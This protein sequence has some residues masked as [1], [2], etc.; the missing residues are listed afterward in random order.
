MQ[1]FSG[2]E[3]LCIDIANNFGKDKT[4][5]FKGDK[6]TFTNRIQWVKDN[7]HKLEERI[8]E[9]D[10]DKYLYIKSVQA[11]RKVC[12]GEATG[13]LVMLDATCS[14]MQ[15]LSALTGCIKGARITNLLKG[16]VRYDAYTEVTNTMQGV[17]NNKG[18]NAFTVNRADAKQA[19]MTSLYGSTATP[20]EIFKEDHIISAFYD[21]CF[22][23]APGAFSTLD[24][25]RR[26]WQPHALYHYWVMPDGFTCEIRV[27]EKKETR[28]EIDELNHHK[29][30][31]SYTV[32]EGSE[33]GISL[34]A[35]V[36]HS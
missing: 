5:G 29:F 17:L 32:N 21:A 2:I 4:T 8:D 10:E 7:F 20:K 13:H 28:V 23:E 34:P 19:V 33:Y 30:R 6:D 25:L 3:Y 22:M 9:V 27:L 15:I 1:H 18:I 31:T 35:N 26:A 11:L 24:V 12:N 16:D 36:T 14:G